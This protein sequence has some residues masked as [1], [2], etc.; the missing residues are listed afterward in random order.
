MGPRQVG[1]T[2]AIRQFLDT[3]GTPFIYDTADLL[4]P[5]STSW[6]EEKWNEAR[7]RAQINDRVILVLDEVQKVTRWSEAVKKFHD[8]DVHNGIHV[9]VVILG[10]SALMVQ[11]GLKE[12]L[13]GRFEIIPFSH[14]TFQECKNAF[15]ISL[16]EY[17]FFG[18]YPGALAIYKEDKDE[19]RWQQYVRDTL[20]ETVIGKDILQLTSID[21]PALLR[22][23]FNLACAHPAEILSYTKMLGQLQDAG[24]TTTIATY[25]NVMSAAGLLVAIS[26]YSGSMIR[27]RASIP[28]IVL[29][30]NALINAAM[31]REFGYAKSKPELWGRLI[32][33]TVGA[34]LYNQLHNRGI[35]I[36]YWRDRDDEIDF[37]VKKGEK[38]IGVEVKSGRQKYGRGVDLFIKRFDGVSVLKVGGANCD[39]GISDFL[40]SD[41]VKWIKL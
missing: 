22:Q 37:V 40:L 18:G 25:L 8:E 19:L 5:P 3:A 24:N 38:I 31:T 2:T 28:K 1:K 14:W 39:V 36:F 34:H 17:I 41:P 35:E 4:S 16:D 26:R 27:Q 10:S 30:N 9:R 11:K 6:I 20:I 29:L 21:K 12:S 23:V 15:G 13:A 7:M 32:E 33:N